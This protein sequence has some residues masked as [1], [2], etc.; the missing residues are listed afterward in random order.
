MYDK[1]KFTDAGYHHY[2]LFFID[3]TTPSEEI[4]QSFIEL[5]EREEGKV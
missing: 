4:L 3:G 5:S 2:D 1:A